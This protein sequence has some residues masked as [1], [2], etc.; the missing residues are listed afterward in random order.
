MKKLVFRSIPRAKYIELVNQGVELAHCRDIV[1]KLQNNLKIKS[2]E[3]RNLKRMLRYYHNTNEAQSQ[4]EENAHRKASFKK[5]ENQDDHGFQTSTENSNVISIFYLKFFVS[6]NLS[7]IICV[8]GEV[9]QI[10]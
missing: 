2:N 5:N 9:I 3:I 10:Y 6:A 7:V 4:G 8:Y 1:K